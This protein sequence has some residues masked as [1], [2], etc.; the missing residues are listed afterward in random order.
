MERSRPAAVEAIQ[1][2][3]KRLEEVV[4]KVGLEDEVSLTAVTPS[5]QTFKT[6]FGREVSWDIRMLYEVK[7]DEMM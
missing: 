4:P 2:A 6:T 7:A 3:M 1:F 5:L